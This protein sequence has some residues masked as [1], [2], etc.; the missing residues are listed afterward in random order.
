MKKIKIR[1]DRNL[2]IGCG[3]C[4]EIEPAVF[5]I[6]KE[7]KSILKTE[8]GKL[9]AEQIYDNHSGRYNKAFD[10]AASCPVNAIT[11]EEIKK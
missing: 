7:E 1:I 8:N 5:S 10:A 6:D 2:C 9:Q 3:C 11:I 4:S